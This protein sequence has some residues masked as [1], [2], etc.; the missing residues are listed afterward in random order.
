[1]MSGG[2]YAW[3]V[4]AWVGGLVLAGWSPSAVRGEAW[5]GEQNPYARVLS[6]YQLELTSLPTDRVTAPLTELAPPN[7]WPP[8]DPFADRG[9]GIPAEQSDDPIPA[10]VLARLRRPFVD[11]GAEWE[12]AAR[13]WELVTADLSV[14]MATPPLFGPPP[15]F[16]KAGFS[17]T[18]LVAPPAAD[19]PSELYDVSLGFDWM[20]E[21]NER[22][23]LRLAF[24]PAYA[25][26][27]KNNSREA[28]Q[29]R[30]AVL[31][32]WQAR[33]TWQAVVGAVASG[34]RD[35]PVFPAAG[36]IW[37]PSP[38]LQLDLLMPQPQAAWRIAQRRGRQQWLYV[39]GGISGGTWAYQQASGAEDVLTY[40]QWRA[41]VGWKSVPTP[42]P[43]VGLSVGHKLAVEVGYVFDRQFEFEG[44]RTDIDLDDTLLVRASFG[45]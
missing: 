30:G 31:G 34:R 41:L 33:E 20:R 13:G 12:A 36:L 6:Q 2:R 35:W 24:A 14:K 5:T 25:S 42:Q 16:V 22:W 32:I 18:D 17:F 15:P 10:E 43:G 45:F 3:L 11:V 38:T 4:W 1:M 21:I 9:V 8:P 39:G 28:W 44:P 7:V 27:G 26:D 40:S 29:F 19:L 37:K 23:M